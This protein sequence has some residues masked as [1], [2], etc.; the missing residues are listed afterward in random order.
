MICRATF[1]LNVVVIAMIIV[2]QSPLLHAVFIIPHV[3]LESAMAC[4]VFRS[5]RL[6][7]IVEIDGST[8]QISTQPLQFAVVLD[9]RMASADG[10]V[11]GRH[12]SRNSRHRQ[13]VTEISQISD[14]AE[15][16][17]NPVGKLEEKNDKPEVIF[18]RV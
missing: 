14:S 3:A 12:G 8:A 15:P 2:P 18:Y 5:L 10:S 9:P 6:H 17:S 16:N 4:R 13:V 11:L 7:F 1:G